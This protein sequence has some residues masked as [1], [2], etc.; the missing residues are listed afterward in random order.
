MPTQTFQCSTTQFASL[1]TQLAAS[2]ITVPDSNS[3]QISGDGIVAGYVY[4]GEKSL[5]VT[6]ISKTGWLPTWSQVFDSIQD[7]LNASA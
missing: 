6:G 1:R 5:V 3:G 4:D 7:H 2:G